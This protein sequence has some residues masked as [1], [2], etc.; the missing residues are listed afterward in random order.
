MKDP[1]QKFLTRFFTS[2]DELK[3]SIQA[4]LLNPSAKAYQF[5][6]SNYFMGRYLKYGEGYPDWSLRLF[7]KKYAHW[8]EDN[9]HEYV[10]TQ[11]DIG[12]LAGDLLHHSCDS[13]TDYLNKQNTYTSL[14]AEKMFMEGKKISSAKIIISPLFRFIKFFIFKRGFLDGLPGFVHISIGCFNTMMKYSKVCDK[15]KEYNK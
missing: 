7:N 3:K 5:A 1:S 8:S 10:V 6:R 2:S 9:V 14:Q 11:T 12:K 15:Q 4:A 13:L